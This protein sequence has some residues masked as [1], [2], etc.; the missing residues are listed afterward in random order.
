M[1]SIHAHFNEI[2]SFYELKESD[3]YAATRRA[4]VNVAA[5]IGKAMK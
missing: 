3:P 4:I 2:E 5:E 1:A